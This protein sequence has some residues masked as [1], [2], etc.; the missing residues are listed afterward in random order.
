MNLEEYTKA[1]E[2]LTTKSEN[3]TIKV[4]EM[5]RRTLCL[6]SANLGNFLPKISG[7]QHERV[8]KNILLNKDKSVLD[9][10]YRSIL[11]HVH[12]ENKTGNIT[13]LLFNVP[14]IIYTFHIGSMQLT[15]HFLAYNKIKYSFIASKKTL[16][17]HLGDFLEMAE[18]QKQNYGELEL[19]YIEADESTSLLK[20]IRALKNGKHLLIYI[21]G[22]IGSGERI[23]EKRN[24]SNIN[25]FDRQISVRSGAAI[26]SYLCEVPMIGVVNYRNKKHENCMYFIDP[27][28][29]KKKEHRLV[30]CRSLMQY[31]YYKF[32]EI[33]NKFP[34]QWE[35]WIYLHLWV[36]TSNFEYQPTEAFRASSYQFNN[37]DFGLFMIDRS[38]YLF[39]KRNYQS[40]FIDE[41][42]YNSLVQYTNELIPGTLFPEEITDQF[43]KRGVF[44]N[45]KNRL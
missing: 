38:C 40:F 41:S 17:E 31:A 11:E 36:D 9:G 5:L 14:S 22:N 29:P 42:I 34:D 24:M 39:C 4:S 37:G 43:L 32:S 21:D 27:V 8:L 45:V 30:E 3:L 18:F 10:K 6:T 23:A 44:K 15:N 1:L 7:E 33:L 35:C 2:N 28:F 26:L 25:F 16:D 13:S 12:Y 19:S 20:M